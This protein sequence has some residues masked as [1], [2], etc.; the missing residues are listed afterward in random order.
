MAPSPAALTATKLTPPRVPPALIS[1][2][3]LL[4]RLDAGVQGPLTLLAAPAG[5]GKSALLTSWV[6]E[7]AAMRVAW[8]SLDPVDGEPHRFWRGVLEALR[9]TGVGDPVESLAVHPSEDVAELLPG[10]EQALDSLDTPIVLILDDLHEV[11][12]SPAVA[13]LDRLLR[14]PPAALRVV[15]STRADPPLRIGRMRVDGTL[16]ELRAADLGFTLDE[17]AELLGAAGVTVAPDVVELLWHR[18]E[19]WAAGL[20]LAALA[21]RT[22]PDPARFVAEFAGVDSTVADYLLAEVLARQ[23]AELREFLLRI[24]VVDEVTG[25][26]ADALTG[27]SD[28][29]RV[30]ARLERDHALLS[31]TGGAGAWHRLHP[32][33]A[34]LLRSELRYTRE[35]AVRDLHRRAASWFEAHGRPTEALRHAAAAEDSEHVAALAGSQ[36]VP[37]LLQGELET[38]RD[39]LDQLPLAPGDADP[40]LALAVA[41]VRVDAGD[42]PAARAWFEVARA[43]RDMVPAERCGDF[44]LATAAVGLLRGRLCG[45]ADEAMQHAQAMFE[46]NGSSPPTDVGTDELRTLAFTHL[47]I[48]ELWSG[49]L[50]RARRDLETAR[51]AALASGRDWMVCGRYER[52]TG[53]CAEAEALAQRRGWSH[54]WPV[55]ITAGTLSVVAY[56]R[57]LLDEAESQLERAADRLQRSADRPLRAM[58]AIQRGRLAIAGGRYERAFEAVQEAREWLRDFPIMPAIGGLVDA[59]EATV[60]AALGN[61]PGAAAQLETADGGI[62][63]EAAVALARLRLRD[64]D[65]GGAL[66]ALRPF[67]GEERSPLRSTRIE[68]WVLAALS[69]DALAEHVQAGAALETALDMAESSTLRRPFLSD[70]AS[71][72]P[73]LRRHIRAGTSHRS[74]VGELLTAVERPAAARTAAVLPESLSERE[75]AVLRFLPTMM[76]NQEIAAELFVSVNTVKTHLKSIYRKLDVDDRRGAVRRARDHALLGPQ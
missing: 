19:G 52:A 5:S 13:D 68:T 60:I 53:L 36:W 14:R 31:S 57:D 39:V 67:R 21:M 11:G 70:G 48:A 56:H 69:H 3:R 29:E 42:E 2:P 38:L 72:A 25:E 26:L 7:Q 28:S 41:G 45:D 71:I 61:A 35:P 75:A 27:R 6:A 66:D 44:D 55:G 30:L 22:H 24:S 12:D 20:R 34:E 46:R 16:T 32:L 49:D 73:L 10:I 65:A 63:Q 62:T 76:S 54:T 23:P 17:T 40:E 37:L 59:L 58:L 18:T 15:V 1:R 43:R 47:G 64:A 4:D 8:L 33:F 50:D 74:L 9:R 51:G